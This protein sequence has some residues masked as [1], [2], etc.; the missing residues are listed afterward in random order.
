[1]GVI[2]IGVSS[3]CSVFG[4]E[5]RIDEEEVKEGR[6]LPLGALFSSLIKMLTFL[7]SADLMTAS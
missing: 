3:S 7:L 6:F 4:R 5:R 2:S 1:M